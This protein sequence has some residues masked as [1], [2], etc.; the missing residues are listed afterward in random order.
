MASNNQF[1]PPKSFVA[2]LAP[3][4][5]DTVKAG[6][7]RRLGAKLLDTLLASLLLMPALIIAVSRMP[8]QALAIR[9]GSF[10]RDFYTALL[11]VGMPLYAGGLVLL[12]VWI[13]NLVLLSRN[14]Q[15]IGKKMLGIRIVRTD[16]SRA[17]LARLFW[18]RTFV[19]GLFTQV[20]MVGRFY[21]LVDVLAI[22]A[23]P[24]R[25]LHDYLADTIVVKA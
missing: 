14:G 15:T 4:A 23:G 13:I 8:N 2:D 10:A 1:S 6:R 9:N 16:G 3:D 24:R 25:C 18:L 7:G 11:G 17:T 22:F 19:S 20:P 21:G 5:A 12:L